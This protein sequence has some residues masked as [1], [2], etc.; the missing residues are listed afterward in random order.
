MKILTVSVLLSLLAGC[1]VE[2]Y[3][4]VDEQQGNEMLALLL[5]N[6]ISSSKSQ[7]KANMISLYV[8]EKQISAAVEV[9]R[10]NGFPKNNFTTIQDM[11]GGNDKLIYTPF[12]DRARYNYGLSQEVAET[13]S[14]I[15]GVI[16]ARVHLVI[17]KETRNKEPTE[18]ASAAIFVKYNPAF[19]FNAYIPEIKAIVANGIAG[20]SYENVSVALFPAQGERMLSDK[21]RPRPL[22]GVLSIELAAKSV[23][24]FY[25]IIGSLL[26]LVFI[27]VV[28]NIYLLLSKNG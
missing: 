3:S 21:H 23:P 11:F 2:L 7:G 5:D 17:P 24:R 12:E 4:Q 16:A 25:L 1:K 19:D 9:L 10:R 26:I 14:Q 28:A 18:P 27:S 6:G 13:L 8:D 22:V 15:D 20:I